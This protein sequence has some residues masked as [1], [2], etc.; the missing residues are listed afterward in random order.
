LF[1]NLFYVN[2]LQIELFTGAADFVT[3][4]VTIP[5]ER[6]HFCQR[7]EAFAGESY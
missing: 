4:Q 6:F 5:L 3:R 2:Q 7:L 1:F